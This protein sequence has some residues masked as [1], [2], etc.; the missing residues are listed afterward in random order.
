[1]VGVTWILY[2]PIAYK[3]GAGT[4]IGIGPFDFQVSRIL[5]YFGFFTLG[6]LIGN[7]NFNSDL[8]STK[9]P[10]VKIWWL[11]LMLSLSVYFLLTIIVGPL[12]QMVK[13]GNIKE[14]IAWMIYYTIYSVSC[15]LSC[16][17]FITTFRKLINSQKLW[18]NSLSENAYLIYLIH[19]IFVIWI[20]FSLLSINIPA[21][22]KFLLT[23]I[24]SLVFSW[25][26]S[27]LLRKFKIIHKYL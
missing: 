23:F 5:L 2:V 19:F 26:T 12:T 20:Q 17:A 7:T 18:W 4:W 15:T 27:I 13:D 22:F 24:I 21:F 25:G 8:F 3:I 11:W 10:I 14:F 6:S 16:I 9:S 1:L